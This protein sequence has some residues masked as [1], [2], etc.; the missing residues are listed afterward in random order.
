MKDT[1]ILGVDPG[2]RVTG[3]GV[4]KVTGT[5]ISVLDGGVV[6]A[7]SGSMGERLQKIYQ[8]LRRVADSYQPTEAAIEK[9][10]THINP[11]GALVLGQARGVAFLSLTESGIK[12]IE[13]YT[14]RQVKQAVVG[15]GA[16][17]KEQV[18]FMIKSMLTIVN[19]LAFDAADALA[20]A[21]CHA[22]SRNA[23][24]GAAS[25]ACTKNEQLQALLKQYPKG[26]RRGRR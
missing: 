25:M 22:H 17:S 4:I 11:A 6:T 3:Y 8:G 9:I 24:N 7:H 2:S 5:A 14:A 21:L 16:A 23:L 20:I 18:R 19:D 26:W 13:E 15:Y 12:T 10:F 1:V